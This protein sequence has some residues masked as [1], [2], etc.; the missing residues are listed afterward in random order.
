MGVHTVRAER[1][2]SEYSEPT[3][4]SFARFLVYVTFVLAI[5]YAERT[6]GI[7]SGARFLHY[8]DNMPRRTPCKTMPG[9]SDTAAT[10]DQAA[11]A[12]VVATAVWPFAHR[13]AGTERWGGKPCACRPLRKPGREHFRVFAR[14]PGHD[15]AAPRRPDH[16]ALRLRPSRGPVAPV[17]FPMP[18]PAARGALSM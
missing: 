15:W 2:V 1:A 12:E 8:F 4:T 5:S 17:L 11:T 14:G 13:T 16:C 3:W 18:R 9:T 10:A 7:G 6:R